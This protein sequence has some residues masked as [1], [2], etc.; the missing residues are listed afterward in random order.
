MKIIGDGKAGINSAGSNV[1]IDT[2][3]NRVFNHEVFGVSKRFAIPKNSSINIIIDPTE[4]GVFP[5]NDFVI[6]PFS[7]STVGA[8]PVEVDIYAG[9]DSDPDGTLWESMDRNQ[10][11]SL[12]AHTKI[13]LNPTINN[14][15]T[16]T[17]LEYCIYSEAG[18][19]NT[20]NVAGGIKTVLITKSRTDLTF[21]IRLTN[22]DTSNNARGVFT[23]DWFEV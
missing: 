1:T 13:R 21:S 9:V 22:L 16:K 6:L 15:G 18:Q 20:A 5:K 7:I 17:H 10:V 12:T 11:E 8:G 19:G 14:I 2:F 23:M 3:N 4:S